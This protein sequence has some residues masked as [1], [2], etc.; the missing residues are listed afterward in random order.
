MSKLFSRQRGHGPKMLFLHGFPMH[1]GIWD[2]FGEFFTLEN[3]VITIDLPGFGKSPLLRQ[4]TDFSLG[5]VADEVISFVEERELSG[6]VLIGH[7]L[8]GYVA[9]AAIEKRPDLFAG[10]ILFH[11][12]AYSDSTE[13]KESRNKVIDFVQ[14]NGALPFTTSF[15][16]PLFADPEH[17]DIEW[18]TQIAATTPEDTIIG[19]TKAMRDRKDEVKTLIRFE[20]PTLFLV[21]EK[22]AGIPVSSVYEQ[23]RGCKNAE[24]HVLDHV[25]HMGMIEKANESAARIKDF[26]KK[27]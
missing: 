17:S 10:L 14:R 26:L 25:A 21:G 6:G 2:H 11:S 1:Q 9:L 4:A 5:D 16:A 18:V 19:Y 3:T 23:A 7:S 24:I 15:I 12:T 22:D 27:I 13:R 20:K 8:G